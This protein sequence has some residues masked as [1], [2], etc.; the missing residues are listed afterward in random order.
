[1]SVGITAVS[2]K[3]NVLKVYKVTRKSEKLICNMSIIII[4]ELSIV[5]IFVGN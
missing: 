5:T 1:M 3:T 2:N 4:N